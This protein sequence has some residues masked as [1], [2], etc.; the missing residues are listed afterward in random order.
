MTSQQLLY[1]KTV[2]E[3]RSFTRAAEKLY[4]SQP[5]L[6]RTIKC[7]E[8]EL[9]VKLIERSSRSFHLTNS[10]EVLYQYAGQLLADYSNIRRAMHDPGTIEAG[11]VK[12]S[13]PAV[14][15]DM[16]F[17]PVFLDF[18]KKYKY[19]SLSITEEGSNSV[20]ESV[21]QQKSDLGLV[22]MPEGSTSVPD[23]YTITPLISYQIGAV[24]CKNHKFAR[25]P[26]I[27]IGD[28]KSEQILTFGE[29]STLY[30]ELLKMCRRQGFEPNINYKCL[31]TSFIAQMIAESFCVGVLPRPLIEHFLTPD[32]SLIDLEENCPWQISLIHDNTAYQSFAAK[33]M[34]SYIIDY[35]SQ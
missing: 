31:T 27:S 14:L 5:L 4:V 28:L 12:L 25:A 1:F 18:L 34:E 7:L 19:V 10:G 26:H 29:S 2:A 17:S 35:F 8:A 30:L 15:L 16:Y 33:T 23:C 32:L 6:T 13:I 24:V 22:M 11:E 3:C 20:F 9:D 21:K